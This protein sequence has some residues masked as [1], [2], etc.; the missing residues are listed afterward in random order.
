MV[1]EMKAFCLLTTMKDRLHT[2]T[3]YGEDVPSRAWEEARSIDEGVAGEVRQGVE[4]CSV[5]KGHRQG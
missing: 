2:L 1:K 3:V 4:V 5:D